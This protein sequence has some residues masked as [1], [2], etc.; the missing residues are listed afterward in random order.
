MRQSGPQAL[1]GVKKSFGGQG[2]GIYCGN[3]YRNFD[4]VVPLGGFGG[5]CG[6]LVVAQRELS[7]SAR[8]ELGTAPRMPVKVYL[9][10]DEKPFRLGP[11]KAILPI[12]SDL[13]YRE[14]LWQASAKPKTLEVTA[15]DNSHFFLLEGAASFELRAGE[16]TN[17]VIALP[18]EEGDVRAL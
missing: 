2:G 12:K 8:L 14:K 15:Y 13:F 9:L 1:T 10:K 3:S 7:L 6:L 16:T 17:V 11:V 4:L 5:G 18:E